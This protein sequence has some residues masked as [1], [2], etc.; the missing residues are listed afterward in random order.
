MQLLHSR[1]LLQLRGSNSK[2]QKGRGQTVLL[3]H[4]ER[5]EIKAAGQQ[6]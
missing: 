5:K 2:K 4:T 3:I 1:G 6:L